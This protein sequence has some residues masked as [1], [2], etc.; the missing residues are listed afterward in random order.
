MHAL[1]PILTP[2]GLFIGRPPAYPLSF[3]PLQPLAYRLFLLAPFTVNL[4]RQC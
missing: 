4:I 2:F 3:S 1:C